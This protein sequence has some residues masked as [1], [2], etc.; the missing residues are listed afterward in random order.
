[1]SAE[2]IIE[3][4]AE[5]PFTPLRIHL[6]D[7]RYHDIRHPELVFVTRRTLAIGVGGD[8]GDVAVPERLRICSTDHVVEVAPVAANGSG[9]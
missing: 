6:A 3:I 7:G 8:E 9:N 5:R 2:E 4:L 1:M